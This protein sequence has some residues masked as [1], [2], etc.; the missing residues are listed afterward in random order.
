VYVVKIFAGVDLDS[1]VP[2]KAKGKD[3][4]IARPKLKVSDFLLLL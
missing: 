4:G 2:V 1:L 3:E